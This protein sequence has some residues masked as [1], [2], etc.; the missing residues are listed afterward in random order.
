M[1]TVP[2][3]TPSGN[4]LIRMEHVAI[5]GASTVGGAQFYISCAQV[6]V[7]GGGSGSPGPKVSIPGV[8]TGNEPGLLINIYWPIRKFSSIE[9]KT[10]WLHKYTNFS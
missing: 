8:Y 10:L 3:S 6:T 2:K 9:G 7:T 5:H 1:F 4:Y